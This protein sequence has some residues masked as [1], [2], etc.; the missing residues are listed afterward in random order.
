MYRVFF[1][2][3]LLFFNGSKFLQPQCL[4]CECQHAYIVEA[5]KPI[6]NGTK[7][8]QRWD[9]VRDISDFTSHDRCSL[10]MS[11]D[12]KVINIKKCGV[13][14]PYETLA[15]LCEGCLK[16][17][18]LPVSSYELMW[19]DSMSVFVCDKCEHDIGMHV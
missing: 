9:H 12:H 14:K 18:M 5:Q 2:V 19:D 15:R 7:K 1:L 3:L 10:C 17:T 6:F 13:Q 16:N 4:F 8:V 11:C